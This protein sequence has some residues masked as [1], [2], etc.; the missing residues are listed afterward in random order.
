MNI[1]RTLT[2]LSLALIL[3]NGCAVLDLKDTLPSAILN[4]QDPEII[5]DGAPAF[6]IIMD[7]LVEADPED[8]DYLFLAAK[9]YSAYAGAFT[10]SDPVRSRRLATRAYDYGYRAL[11]SELNAF[12][13]QIN[14]PFDAFEESLAEYATTDNVPILYGFA[15]VWATWLR[16]HSSD[17]EAIA[18]LAKIKALVATIL[19]LNETHDNGNAHL[20]MGVLDSQLPPTLGGKPEKARIHFERVIELSNGRNLFAK[21]LF[22]ENYARLVFDREL[23]D[24]LLNEVISAD[25]VEQNLTLTNTLAQEKAKQLLAESEDYFE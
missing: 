22:A 7:A 17:W 4:Q 8:S 9:L 23:H 14:Q 18:Q 1:S 21:V 16:A 5:R 25:P 15:T 24:Q 19:D 2:F 20:Y 3:L 13:K 10:G 11:C 6:L 12:C